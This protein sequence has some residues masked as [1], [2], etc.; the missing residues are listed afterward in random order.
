MLDLLFWGM[1][2]SLIIA[3]IIIIAQRNEINDLKKANENLKLPF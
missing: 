3:G 1:W 2:F